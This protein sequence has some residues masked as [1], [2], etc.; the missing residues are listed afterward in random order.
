MDNPLKNPER[1]RK[2][3]TSFL[4]LSIQRDGHIHPSLY[5]KRN[6]FIFHISKPYHSG[7]V[8][9]SWSCPILGLACVLILRPISPELVLF[10][11]FWVSNILWYF[12]FAF[13][14]ARQ[15]ILQLAADTIC[16]SWSSYEYFILRVRRLSNKQL[17]TG[18]QKFTPWN[19]WNRHSVSLIADTEI[20]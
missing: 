6:V 5:E 14:F 15:W 1:E 9:W 12:C 19:A 18:I 7:V 3:K 4:P 10:L 16:Q 20:S 11:D 13:T 17:K 2:S 8:I